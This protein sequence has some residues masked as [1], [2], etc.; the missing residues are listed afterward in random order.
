[1]Y[2]LQWFFNVICVTAGIE[3]NGETNSAADVEHFAFALKAA[4]WGTCFWV[5]SVGPKGGA[6]LMVFNRRWP[7]EFKLLS[8][9]AS[10]HGTLV[11]SVYVG[12]QI[13][14]AGFLRDMLDLVLVPAM[15]GLRRETGLVPPLVPVSALQSFVRGMSLDGRTRRLGWERN[16]VQSSTKVTPGGLHCGG[17]PL[18]LEQLS[19]DTRQSLLDDD[20]HVRVYLTSFWKQNPSRISLRH[21]G[22]YIAGHRATILHCPLRM[23]CWTPGVGWDERKG[24][25]TD[26]TQKRQ[27]NHSRLWIFSDI[28]CFSCFAPP[29]TLELV[30]GPPRS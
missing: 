6:L 16:D 5:V 25:S 29:G 4:G 24:W 8:V 1:M 10:M 30:L 12:H 2:V 15:H 18:G 3:V 28:I 17:S 27:K 22:K 9:F 20:A 11:G 19:V 26:T 13:D 14:A 23:V 7:R 21:L